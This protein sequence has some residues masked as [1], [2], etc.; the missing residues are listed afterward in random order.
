MS[1]RRAALA[2]AAVAAVAAVALAGLGHAARQP[3]EEERLQIEERIL[4]WIAC[5]VDAESGTVRRT[6]IS[7]AS[8]RFARADVRIAYPAAPALDAV[9]VLRKG[10]YGWKVLDAGTHALGCAGVPAKARADLGLT[11]RGRCLTS[12]R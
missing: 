6:R 10:P 5:C 1:T 9:A 12:G 4:A 8:P 11:A 3:N 7:T 2:F